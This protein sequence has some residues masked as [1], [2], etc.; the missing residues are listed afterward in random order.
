MSISHYS[1]TMKYGC[2]QN[3]G[4]YSNIRPELEVTLS[5]DGDAD[6]AKAVIDQ[7]FENIINT[8][9]NTVDHELELHGKPVLYW[10]G[11][12]YTLLFAEDFDFWAIV[13]A[14]ERL[15]ELWGSLIRYGY[16]NFRYETM[17][18][19]LANDPE[20]ASRL[21]HLETCATS[22]LPV[23]EKC[24]FLKIRHPALGRMLILCSGNVATHYGGLEKKAV[25]L[26]HWYDFIEYGTSGK[27]VI[28]PR[29]L[30]LAKMRELALNEGRTIYDCLDHD[31]AAL[32]E[33]PP[34]PQQA[35]E[36]SD[37]TPFEEDDE[38]DIDED[39]EDE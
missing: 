1:V 24:T 15:P 38:D 6:E 33:L 26:A 35:P 5:G 9:H 8:V 2:T 32:P 17:L 36:E 23:L 31:F 18:S 19:K 13:P 37:D 29:S 7:A 34:E 4:D 30:F 20:F 12:T 25:P 21:E 16:Q 28:M 22:Q 27:C 10:T 39:E 14:N 3:V 11:L